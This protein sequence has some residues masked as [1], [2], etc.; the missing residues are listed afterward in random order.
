M[1]SVSNDFK[2]AFKA[3][4]REIEAYV[5]ITGSNN[6]IQQNYSL[7]PNDIIEMSV[8]YP[9][10]TGDLASCG[11]VY[12]SS[13]T[14]KIKS[15]NVPASF[16]KN[17][18]S[19]RV[20]PQVAVEVGEPPALEYCDLGV[21]MVNRRTSTDNFQTYTI[22]GQDEV[23]LLDVPYNGWVNNVMHYNITVVGQPIQYAGY[24]AK[25]V[26]DDI[27]AYCGLTLD[28]NFVMPTDY[29]G[30]ALSLALE[31]SE[32][33]ESRTARQ[34][35][36]LIGGIW[37]A[38][39][40][41]TRDGYFTFKSYTLCPNALDN[42]PESMQY[43]G[44]LTRDREDPQYL[45]RGFYHRDPV[46]G[47]PTGFTP[48]D[49]EGAVYLN[50]DLF[51]KTAYNSQNFA[52][53]SDAFKTAVYDTTKYFVGGTLQYRGM[54]WLECGDMVNIIYG[55]N[56]AKSTNCFMISNHTLNITGGMV[57]TMRCYTPLIQ[58]VDNTSSSSG[59]YNE[60]VSVGAAAAI[61]AK[62]PVGSV[63]VT[64]GNVNPEATFG[65]SWT[66]IDKEFISQSRTATVTRNT[67]NFSALSVTAIY[68]GH[69]ITFIGSMTSSVS[70]GETNL[71]VMTQTLS[72]NGASSLPHT[73]PFVG[74]TDGGNA[75]IMIDIDTAGRV[76][77]L[78]VVVRGTGTSVASGNT[79]DWS[80]TCPCLYTA[81]Q[82]SFCDK[83]YWK[84]TA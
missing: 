73:I 30:N 74:Y 5:T 20:K 77:T 75:V 45:Y 36:G 58:E 7:T 68:E 63:L 10:S 34:W 8:E 26:I 82:D 81:M 66:L 33:E 38:N 51:L 3:R 23:S 78:D 35:L 59:S 13:L 37:G 53:Y 11:E 28:P 72:D 57:G 67:T 84:R 19:I 4:T 54:P 50:S 27:L 39:G 2:S 64:S 56:G 61:N 12:C 31:K 42:I 47:N 62:F 44:G 1:V 29:N 83:F 18:T 16:W 76:R 52:F 25:Q 48:T 22:E 80:V 70:M 49:F 17:C 60:S 41:M 40:M 43:M 55:Y 69:N 32:A 15:D 24:N 65:G 6:G 14:L 71:E 21:F 9:F 46:I 79:F